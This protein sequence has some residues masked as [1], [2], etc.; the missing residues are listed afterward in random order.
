MGEKILGS[1]P[2]AISVWLKSFWVTSLGVFCRMRDTVT[3]E[4]ET[5][6]CGGLEI[7]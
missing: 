1:V 4:A 3:H 5:F 7:L 2:T 6:A